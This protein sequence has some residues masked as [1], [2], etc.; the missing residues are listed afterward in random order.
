MLLQIDAV[1]DHAIGLDHLIFE[2]FRLEFGKLFPFWVV[3]GSLLVEVNP[4][5]PIGVVFHTRVRLVMEAV[6]GATNNVV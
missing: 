4:E 1:V 3:E 5:F 6:E 2:A